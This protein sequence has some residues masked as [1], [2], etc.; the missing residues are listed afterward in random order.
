MTHSPQDRPKF[1]LLSLDGGGIRGAFIAACLAV[2]EK[3]LG[4]PVV[5]YFDLIAGTST[6]GIIALSL[7]LGGPAEQ[8]QAFYQTY[9]AQIFTRRSPLPVPLYAK[10]LLPLTRRFVKGIPDDLD[11]DWIRQPKYDQKN[12]RRTLTEVFGTRTLAD[13]RTRVVVPA[14]DTIRG[15]TVVFKTP[16]QPNF[17]RDRHFS[18]V[19]IA[20]ATAAAPTYFPHAVIGEGSSY[21]D[22]GLWANNPSMVAYVEAVKIGAVCSRPELD[23]EFRTDEIALLSIGTGRPRYFVSPP[24]EKAGLLWWSH[25]LFD[26]VSTS[27]SQ[28]VDFQCQYVLGDQYQRIDFDQPDV[29]ALDSVEN[30]NSLIHLGHEEAA[31]HFANCRNLF[32]STP[33]QQYHPFPE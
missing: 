26:V 23:P 24:E 4:Q 13:A 18:A 1:K 31:K 5:D 17:I 12:L 16:H 28:S 7:A 20:L 9:G 2:L 10:L 32:F 14:V 33:A 25:K 6:G 30:L 15:Q 19:D 29:W 8:I 11:T 27:Q 3:R 22:G 21:L